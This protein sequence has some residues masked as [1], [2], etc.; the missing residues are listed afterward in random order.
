MKSIQILAAIALLV[1][2]AFA[3]DCA[4][5]PGS[6]C[7]DRIPAICTG[8]RPPSCADKT[9]TLATSAS[10]PQ[11]TICCSASYFAQGGLI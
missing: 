7:G 1:P 10:V 2:S 3:L 6:D 8:P 5:R 11:P 4:R 9:A